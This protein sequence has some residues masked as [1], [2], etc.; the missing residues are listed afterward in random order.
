MQQSP[1]APFYVS[2]GVGSWALPRDTI[3]RILADASAEPEEE[4]EQEEAEADGSSVRLSPESG[5]LYL[6]SN[7]KSSYPLD[8]LEE[9]MGDDKR[10]E[11]AADSKLVKQ[12]SGIDTI[13]R[14]VL[15]EP[16]VMFSRR[17]LVK[18]LSRQNTQSKHNLQW[19][20]HIS[21]QVGKGSIHSKQEP[22]TV[23]IQLPPA[24]SA[25]TKETTC[26]C[27]VEDTVAALLTRAV[28]KFHAE[29]ALASAGGFAV[30][31]QPTQPELINSFCRYRF[32]PAESAWQK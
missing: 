22:F 31:S 27:T 28:S 19:P 6:S 3:V 5:L 12:L 32:I 17:R 29:G 10:R 16:D 14:S 8:C 9:V 24:A 13:R 4:I 18:W 1:P 11:K 25:D 23:T 2:G 7:G 21:S 20:A 15:Q 30:G 26:Q